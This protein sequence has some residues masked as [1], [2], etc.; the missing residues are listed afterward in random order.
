VDE[1]FYFLLF[2]VSRGGVEILEFMT[3]GFLGRRPRTPGW[4][5]GTF[6]SAEDE[7]DI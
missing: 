1:G 6:F 5:V 2:Q 3:F 7:V 4:G